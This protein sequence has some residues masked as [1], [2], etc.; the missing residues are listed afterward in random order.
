MATRVGEMDIKPLCV[1][2]HVY[3]VNGYVNL[4][5]KV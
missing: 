4:Q 3:N 5:F 2:D 1:H